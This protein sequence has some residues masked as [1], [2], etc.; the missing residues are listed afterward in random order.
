MS[1]ANIVISNPVSEAGLIRRAQRGDTGAF[2]N[3]FN[4]HKPRV[5]SLCLRM[6][7]NVAEAEDL[8]QEAFLQVF[9]KLPT[10]RGDSALSTWMYR[11]AVNTVLMY[12][13]KRGRPQLSLDEPATPNV[14]SK[15]REYGFDDQRLVTSIDRI[16][17]TR[18]IRELPDGYRTI[19]LLH[20]IEGY[21]HREIAKLLKCSVGNSKS[22]LHKARLKMREILS[23]SP[24]GK[25][26]IEHA[27][28]SRTRGV[29]V[30]KPAVADLR[31]AC[32]HGKRP[33]KKTHPDKPVFVAPIPADTQVGLAA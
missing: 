33:G 2:A 14:K 13:R 30:A 1:V 22:Q 6:T 21:E 4:A 5:Y 31:L 23:Q 12:F 29:T 8:T 26:V 28:A 18:A 17:L 24:E 27:K 7:N 10:F 11:V 3:I 32:S 25:A 15:K 16:A 20:E 9:R 19:F